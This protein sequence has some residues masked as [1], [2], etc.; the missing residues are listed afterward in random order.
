MKKL[1]RIFLSLYR[2]FQSILYFYFIKG[3]DYEIFSGYRHRCNIKY[4][5]DLDNSDN[6]QL[7]VYKTAEKIMNE[8][9]LTS[10]YDIGCGSGYK[11]IKI[12]GH[13]ETVGIDLPETISV[14][15]KRYPDRKW[16]VQSG[17]QLS[18]TPADL[19]I[20]SDVIEHVSDPVEL[21]ENIIKLARDW[22]IISTPDRDLVY[23]N[24]IFDHFYYGPPSNQSHVREWNML[25][26]H[27]FISKYMYIEH[28]EISNWKQSTQMIIARK[29][30]S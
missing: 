12:L 28:H 2:Y 14:V 25:E 4:F 15:Q 1:S 21:L 24:H 30:T 16:L 10:V 13:Y 22:I 19:I 11:L 23:K 9:N 29:I 3:G 7:E 17:D 8:N 18:M 20:C 6:W 5:N 26:F 27:K